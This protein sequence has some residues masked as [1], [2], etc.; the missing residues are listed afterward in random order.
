MTFRLTEAWLEGHDACSD[1]GIFGRRYPD[2]VVLTEENLYLALLAESK[3]LNEDNGDLNVNWFVYK[4]A[5]FAP[6]M[7]MT[8]AIQS[9]YEAPEEW[10]REVCSALEGLGVAWPRTVLVDSAAVAKVL[11]EKRDVSAR[12]TAHALLEAIDANP[13]EFEDYPLLRTY[14]VDWVE[15]MAASCLIE[16]KDEDDARRKAREGMRNGS[17]DLDWDSSG[18]EIE[19]VYLD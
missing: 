12:E 14:R 9:A 8:N 2:G 10:A 15:S 13:E 1:A 19:S 5:E 3:G 18:Y 11:D 4:V 7:E 16:A 6:T 17:I